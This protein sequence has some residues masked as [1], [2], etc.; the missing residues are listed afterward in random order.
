MTITSA[1]RTASSAEHD[2]CRQFL[3]PARPR[4][5]GSRLQILTSSNSLTSDSARK[6]ARA[7]TPLPRIA[8]LEML[9]GV[10]SSV[11]T[12]ETAAVRNSV[13]SRPSITRAARRWLRVEEARSP[14]GA[15]S[16]RARRFRVDIDQLRAHQLA[17]DR[18]HGA[19][20]AVVLRNCYDAADGLETCPEEKSISAFSIAGIK[21]SRRSSGRMVALAQGTELASEDRRNSSACHGSHPG[22]QRQ[23]KNA[24]VKFWHNES[25]MLKVKEAV[26]RCRF[27][28]R[29][30]SRRGHWLRSLLCRKI[31]RFP[32]RG[33]AGVHTGIAIEF[34]PTA[35]GIV[36]TRSGL[37]K[38][39]LM[40][41]A[42]VIDA[43]Y[44]GEII[45]LMENLGDERVHHPQGR[46][47]CA[48]ARAS[49]SWQAKSWKGN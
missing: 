27:A 9:D 18:G 3:R 42:G 14:P 6:C 1:P 40:C 12:A 48:V 37:A 49:R 38:K 20:Q 35:G 45:V 11:A 19:H 16:G 36:K 39:R 8:R 17:I 31:S 23:R 2:S 46:Q 5:Q 15:S 22:S 7:C 30:S 24:S 25:L 28:D 29:R 26:A 13:I 32:A 41:N 47:D 43:G 4:F 33:A 21:S 44:R 10:S 34:V